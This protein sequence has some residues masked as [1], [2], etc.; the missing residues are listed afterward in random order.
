VSVTIH[1]NEDQHEARAATLGDVLYGRD[2][3]PRVPES[4][5]RNLVRDIAAADQGALQALYERTHR[6]VFTLSMRILNDRP[7]AE[8]VT[9]DV[10]HDVWRRAS[11]YDPID[12]SVIGWIM[13]LTRSRAIDRQRFEQRKK[14]AGP[15]PEA[16]ADA[17]MNECEETADITH[18]A[19]L[20][21]R[22]LRL[23]NP[24]E[25][26]AIE[27]AYLSE[28]TYAETAAR[29]NVPLGTLKTR[30]R[31]GLVKL[32]HAFTIGAEP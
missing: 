16:A 10:F 17:A 22:A 2:T 8:E 30:I 32:R 24:A 19:R 25:R 11:Q 20:L 4:E 18:R 29:L 26:E 14:R 3:Q 1:P 12:G 15:L 27:T 28:L 21:Q 5:W 7:S 13:N 9:L 6:L 23:L 31:S